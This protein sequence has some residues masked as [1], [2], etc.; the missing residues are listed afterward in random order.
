MADNKRRWKVVIVCAWCKRIRRRDGTYGAK[1]TEGFED[2]LNQHDE[3]I[4]HGICP[5]CN[6]GIKEKSGGL[7]EGWCFIDDPTGHERPC[8]HTKIEDMID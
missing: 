7:C 1:M 3:Q 6:D 5:E 4:S 2:F 8:E